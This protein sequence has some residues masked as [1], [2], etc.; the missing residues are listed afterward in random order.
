[1]LYELQSG[2][3]AAYSKETCLVDL[4]NYICQNFDEGNYDGMVLDLQKAFNILILLSKLQCMGLCDTAVK[5]F[6]SYLTGRT[7]VCDV[8]ET[9]SDPELITCGVLQGSILGPL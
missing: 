2:F 1:M 8:E 4:F 3:R 5:W 9:T 6:T 7:K